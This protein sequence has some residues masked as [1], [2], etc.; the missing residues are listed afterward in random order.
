VLAKVIRQG[1]GIELAPG[2]AAGHN[3]SAFHFEFLISPLPILPP[4]PANIAGMDGG[5][6]LRGAEPRS[7]PRFRNFVS[8]LRVSTQRQGDSGLGLEAQRIAVAAHVTGGE[9]LAE[10]LEIESGKKNDRPQLLAALAHAQVTGATLIIARLDRLARNLAFIANLMEAG[11]DFI[12]T[13]LPFATRLT[14]HVLAAVAEYERE[15]ISARTK[16][17]AKARGVRLGNPHGARAL[18]AAAKGNTAAL[19]ALKASAAAWR[20]RVCRSSWRSARAG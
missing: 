11:V 7:D 6:T 18:L 3:R 16:A 8:Y 10:Y 1:S 4:S 2:L 20:A 9:V 13:D 14:I 15:M 12:A 5:R 17:A 19:A